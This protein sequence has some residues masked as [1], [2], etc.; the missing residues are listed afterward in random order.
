MFRFSFNNLLGKSI[1]AFWLLYSYWMS[2]S[3]SSWSFLIS[4]SGFFSV[5]GQKTSYL[6]SLKRSDFLKALSTPSVSLSSE[7]IHCAPALVFLA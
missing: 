7:E 6:P 2:F 5:A 4:N 3:R 1:A